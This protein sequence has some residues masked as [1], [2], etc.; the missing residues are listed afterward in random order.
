MDLLFHADLMYK[1]KPS[2][3]INIYRQNSI[4]IIGREE[5]GSVKSP[6]FSTSLSQSS[7]I[8]PQVQVSDNLQANIPQSFVR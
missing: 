8:P 7:G 1:N 6:P 4:Y 3:A 2:I 5:K